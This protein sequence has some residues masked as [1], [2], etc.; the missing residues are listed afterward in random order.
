MLVRHQ[1]GI[2]VGVSVGGGNFV[3]YWGGG[4]CIVVLLRRRYVVVLPDRDR[5]WCVLGVVGGWEYV[6]VLSDGDRYWCVSRW[7]R[8]LVCQQ[9][10]QQCVV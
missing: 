6:A 4:A 9:G 2:C 10:E 5:H 8:T 1:V 7:N 3:C